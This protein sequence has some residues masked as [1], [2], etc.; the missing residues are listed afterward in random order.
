MQAP[1][2]RFGFTLLELL[3]VITII[4]LLASVGLASYSRAQARARDAR[5][6][7]DLTTMRNSLEIYYAENNAYVSTGDVWRDVSDALVELDPTYIR[8]LPSDPGGSGSVSYRY[9][10][11]SNAQGYCI[12]ANL[13]TAETTQSSCTVTLESGYDYGVGNP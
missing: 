9:R 10:S 12:A 13:E 3:V 6:Q 2:L 5:R 11:I 4:G 1:R 7:S 8:G